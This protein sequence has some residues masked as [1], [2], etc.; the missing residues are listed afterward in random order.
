MK[1]IFNNDRTGNFKKC[2][3]D[4]DQTA[5]FVPASFRGPYLGSSS[6]RNFSFTVTKLILVFNEIREILEAVRNGIY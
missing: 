3:F 6:S 1:D 4:G 2:L 5:S